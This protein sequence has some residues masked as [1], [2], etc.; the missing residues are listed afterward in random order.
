MNET[1]AKPF[2]GLGG[3]A[4]LKSIIVSICTFCFPVNNFVQFRNGFYAICTC[5]KK[6][7]LETK[8]NFYIWLSM[9]I[10]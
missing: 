1:R 6:V 10:P 7:L 4:D 8:E 2:S 9:K 3:K 5:Y